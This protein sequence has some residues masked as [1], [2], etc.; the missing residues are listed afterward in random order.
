M[1]APMMVSGLDD[2]GLND[3]IARAIDILSDMRGPGYRVGPYTILTSEAIEFKITIEPRMALRFEFTGVKPRVR[4]KATKYLISFNFDKAV[5]AITIEPGKVTLF[6]DGV[7]PK[8]VE[9]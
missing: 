4:G 8:I 2:L 3:T 6:I 9:F 7:D 1:T 5:D